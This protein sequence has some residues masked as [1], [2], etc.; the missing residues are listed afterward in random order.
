M[1]SMPGPETEA[2]AALRV[3]ERALA[4]RQRL[5]R[6]RV[7]AP[8]DRVHADDERAADGDQRE[9][10]RRRPPLHLHPGRRGGHLALGRL[11]AREQRL[12]EVPDRP[13]EAVARRAL[14]PDRGGA[15]RRPHRPSRSRRAGSASGPA[16]RPAAR[17]GGPAPASGPCAWRR[18]RSP[19]TRAPRRCP[20]PSA[21]TNRAWRCS[22]ADCGWSV[23]SASLRASVP[24]LAT[25]FADTRHSESPTLS[26][27]RHTSGSSTS[28]G[29]P[30]SRLG[31]GS[32]DRRAWRM[33]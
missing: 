28:T 9:Q 8:A 30:R 31:S 33:R 6:A 1:R 11:A 13:L 22:I 18:P 2:S 12:L 26:S 20:S 19:R 14:R 4:G 17:R 25:T 32:V 21:A 16:G 23:T 29:R 7:L 24:T 27:P 10:R 3:L 15:R 5:D